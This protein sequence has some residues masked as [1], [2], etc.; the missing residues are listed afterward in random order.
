[1]DLDIGTPSRDHLKFPRI[2]KPVHSV[3]KKV[4]EL[5]EKKRR[6]FDNLCFDKPVH[7]SSRRL[8]TKSSFEQPVSEPVKK[9]AKYLKKM[10]CHEES[11]LECHTVA[12][13]PK[14][15]VKEDESLLITGKTPQSS[16]PI[17]DSETE[18]R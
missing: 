18:K 2:A 4:K 5:A 17:V 7:K 12:N 16:F 3:K 15:P 13:T 6:T 11:L 14:L 8:V 10:A 9:K 1:M